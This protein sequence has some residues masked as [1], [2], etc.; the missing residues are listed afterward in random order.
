[1]TIKLCLYVGTTPTQAIILVK[2]SILNIQSI[3]CRLYY[4][5]GVLLFVQHYM[6]P[7]LKILKVKALFQ[8]ML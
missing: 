8:N 2:S 1:M 5:S 4:S 3:S 6:I 7:P